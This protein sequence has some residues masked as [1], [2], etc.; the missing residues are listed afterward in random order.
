MDAAKDKDFAI[1][2]TIFVLITYG[3]ALFL[4]NI[5]D[6]LTKAFKNWRAKKHDGLPLM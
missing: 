2:T 1:I 5:I 6:Y 4:Q 3:V